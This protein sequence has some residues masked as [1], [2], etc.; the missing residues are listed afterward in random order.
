M[1]RVLSRFKSI[2]AD[3]VVE[4]VFA[5]SGNKFM[6][7][8]GIASNPIRW[9]HCRQDHPSC[10]RLAEDDEV[11]LANPERNILIAGNAE[12]KPKPLR[13]AYPPPVTGDPNSVKPKWTGSRTSRQ[14]QTELQRRSPGWLRRFVLIA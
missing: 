2:H 7:D 12:T 10:G 14:G 8:V 3:I 4:L 11:L 1:R 5:S 13:A 9:V 6:Q